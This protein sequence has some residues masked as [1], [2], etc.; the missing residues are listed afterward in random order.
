MPNNASKLLWFPAPTP[1]AYP[2]PQNWEF[3]IL[4]IKDNLMSALDFLR[5]VYNDK[6]AGKPVRAAGEIFVQI[7]T[8]LKVQAELPSD[9]VIAA[10]KIHAPISR[11][12]RQKVLLFFPAAKAP[13]S[14]SSFIREE[15]PLYEGGPI[16]H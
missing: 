1:V 10:I 11:A 16:W 13:L 12:A 3:Q 4:E 5:S 6:L 2:L 9:T 14:H 8:I 7:E 15:G